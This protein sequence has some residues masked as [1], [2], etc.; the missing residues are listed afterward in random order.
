M[1]IHIAGRT[2][3]G[4]A[5]DEYQYVNSAGDGIELKPGDYELTVDST[6]QGGFDLYAIAQ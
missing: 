6:P 5:I 2:L 3:R 1:L 4:Q